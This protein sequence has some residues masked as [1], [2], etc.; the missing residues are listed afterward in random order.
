MAT[1]VPFM[2]ATE[3]STPFN[4]AAKA[5]AATSAIDRPSPLPKKMLPKLLPLS[6]PLP[7]P[8][9]KASPERDRV[10]PQLA[11]EEGAPFFGT[12]AEHCADF[13]GTLAPRQQ[14]SKRTVNATSAAQ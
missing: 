13:S 7:S 2:H 3:G 4:A 11:G 6:T 5:A 12:P 8:E 14:H 9:K 1:A 10:H